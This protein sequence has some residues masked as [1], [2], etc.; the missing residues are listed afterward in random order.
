MA[1]GRI[2]SLD[3][4]MGLSKEIHFEP[5]AS[6]KVESIFVGFMTL[7]TRPLPARI[8]EIRYY[9]PGVGVCLSYLPN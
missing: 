6:F 9:S 8:V 4:S 5:R 7:K 3:F 2:F 1:C